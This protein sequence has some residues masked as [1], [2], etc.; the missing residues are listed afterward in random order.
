MS[1]L[2]GEQ[3]YEKYNNKELYISDFSRERLNPNSYNLRLSRKLAKYTNNV[4]DMKKPNDITY[5]DIPDEG[6]LLEPGI[7]Y[8]GRTL[9]RTRTSTTVPMLEGRSSIGRLGMSI[10]VTA[11]F[12]DIGFDG[13]WT[14]EITVVQPLMIYPEVEVCQ[15]YYHTIEEG[16]KYRPYALD[17]KYN[18][19]DGIQPSLLYRDFE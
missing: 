5:I 9:E 2:T 12:G 8:L 16:A 19:N 15:I 4:L 3:I 7:V 11:G 18:H 1:I 13:Y 17:A 6:Y 14:L 10:H